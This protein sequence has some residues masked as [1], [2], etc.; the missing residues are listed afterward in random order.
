M[1]MIHSA[2]LAYRSVYQSASR[3]FPRQRFSAIAFAQQA[4]RAL[5]AL[6]TPA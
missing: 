2:F 6:L 1:S 4:D 5:A 3:V